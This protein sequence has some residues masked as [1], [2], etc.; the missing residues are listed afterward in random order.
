MQYFKE[1]IKNQR[2]LAVFIFSCVLLNF[3]FIS[4]VNNGAYT[5]GMP[6]MFIY[7]FVVWVLLIILLFIINEYT[8]ND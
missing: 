4:I 1:I 3:P 8:S 6:V 2:L 7:I 5:L